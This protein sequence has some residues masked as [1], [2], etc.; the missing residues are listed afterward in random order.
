MPIYE[1]ACTSCRRKFRKLVGVV[2]NTSPLQCPRCQST[3]VE[4]LIS[5]FSRVRDEDAHLDSL[6]EEMESM[7]DTE[8]PRAMRRLVREMGKEMGED[9]EDEFEQMLEEEQAGGEGEGASPD[10]GEEMD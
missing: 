2:A 6:A 9:M 10:G 3:E 5:R 1:Y 8:D 4:R 7:G